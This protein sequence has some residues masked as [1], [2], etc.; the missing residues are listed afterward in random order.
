MAHTFLFVPCSCIFDILP[1]TD[2]PK[3][4][5]LKLETLMAANFPRDYIGTVSNS[6]KPVLVLH[7]T[8]N[9]AGKNAT[10]TVVIAQ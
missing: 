10:Q 3:R 5:G 2:T 1:S 6:R 8:E 4:I 9:I 7:T